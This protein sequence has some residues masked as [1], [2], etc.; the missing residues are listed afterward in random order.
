[1]AVTCRADGAAVTPRRV[2]GGG[3]GGK[4]IRERM[5]GTAGDDGAS[6]CLIEQITETVAEHCGHRLL[7]A[8]RIACGLT[9][10]QAVA[11]VHAFLEDHRLP[12][13]GLTERSWKDW[14][15]GRTPSPEYADLLARFFA[16]GPVQLGLAVDYS[17][18]A[19][20]IA[21]SEPGQDGTLPSGPAIPSGPGMTP[22]SAEDATHRRD[23]VKLVGMTMLT[24]GALAAVLSDAAGEAFEFTRQAE[25]GLLGSGT[26]DHLELTIAQLDRGY[27]VKPPDQLFAAALYYRRHTGALLAGPLTLRQ[28]RTVYCFAG[29]LSELLAWLANDLG[30]A[31][32]GAAFAIDAYTHAV[33]AEHGELAAW[34]MDAAASIAIYGDRPVK[35]LEFALRGAAVAPAGHPLAVR[36]RAQAAR[37]HART[38]NTDGYTEQIT[39]AHRAFETLPARPTDRFGI[40]TAPLAEYALTSYPATACLWLGQAEQARRHAEDA[41]R[42]YTTVTAESRS[43]SR[44]AIARL[45]L[46]LAHAQ[47]GG[48]DD[49][50]HLGDQALR[51][52]RI[53]TSVRSRASDLHRYL[54]RRWPYSPHT[55]QFGERLAALEPRRANAE[56]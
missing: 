37:A 51:G 47:L 19:A 16:T 33:E 52:E 41:P 10:E 14:E 25:A 40:D 11:G 5:L 29:W 31:H 35:A 6:A 45:D 50:A 55:D 44:E 3:R 56:N 8:R 2:P 9:V 28:R 34:A 12:P 22:A 54:Q 26:L 23:L 30:A 39:L 46:A 42:V 1:M 43:P 15:A 48:L 53:V 36:M 24:P 17:P 49:A 27:S 18:A 20:P 7:K 38:G 21:L 13:V 32:A 4:A